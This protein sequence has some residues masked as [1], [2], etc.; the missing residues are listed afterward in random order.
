MFKSR[1]CAAFDVYFYGLNI[2][3][4]GMYVCDEFYG[5]FP[6]IEFCLGYTIFFLWTQF[7]DYFSLRKMLLIIP[8]P[9]YWRHGGH[10][11]RVAA[12]IHI[13][14]QGCHEVFCEV[15]SP[16]RHIFTIPLI[17]LYSQEM[18]HGFIHF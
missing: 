5:S 14:F 13:I 12:E 6:F 10:Y 7:I 15:C 16:K 2:T 11:E 3:G 17:D 18:L 9:H 8:F 4:G 1:Q